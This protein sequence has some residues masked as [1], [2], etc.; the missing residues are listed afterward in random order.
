MPYLANLEKGRNVDVF[1]IPDKFVD[2]SQPV[3][4]STADV[5]SVQSLKRA[6]WCAD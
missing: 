4:D 1:Q 3:R 5:C 2:M 6:S